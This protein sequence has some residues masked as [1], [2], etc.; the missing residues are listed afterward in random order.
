VH[1]AA[2]LRVERGW[3]LHGAD[4]L[5]GRGQREQRRG[6]VCADEVD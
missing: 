4:A 6:R 1:G 3:Q 5:G 2:L